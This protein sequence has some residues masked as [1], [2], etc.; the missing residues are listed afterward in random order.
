[1]LWFWDFD[2]KN[3]KSKPTP[4]L[5]KCL[6]KKQNNIQ[7]INKKPAVADAK[8]NSLYKEHSF[9]LKLLLI[10]FHYFLGGTTSLK[11]VNAKSYSH[12]HIII[13]AKLQLSSSLHIVGTLIRS[14]CERPSHKMIEQDTILGT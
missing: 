11:L 7:Y 8:L 14:S 2:L 10:I 1:M 4:H 5:K 3:V 12:F 9:I 6:K 13:F